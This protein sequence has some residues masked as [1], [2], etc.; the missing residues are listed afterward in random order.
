MVPG[1]N[2]QAVGTDLICR[3]A[4]GSDTV[5]AYKYTVYI[6]LFHCLRCHAV[7]YEGKWSIGTFQLPG[8]ETR[9]LKQ[10]PCFTNMY[11]KLFPLGMG[12]LDH[13]QRSTNPTG[14]QAA[15]VAN[16][17]Y[18]PIIGDKIGTM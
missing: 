6:H 4:I 16:G 11:L 3:I 5:S 15:S 13:T 12:V 18:I 2:S 7:C 17:H 1:Q 14:G 10:G 8:V 9:T